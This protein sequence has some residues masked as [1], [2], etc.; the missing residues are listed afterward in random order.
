MQVGCQCACAHV[1]GVSDIGLPEPLGRERGQKYKHCCLPED[2][3]ACMPLIWCDRL[4]NAMIA[5]LVA[6]CIS[7][8]LLVLAGDSHQVLGSKGRTFAR[9]LGQ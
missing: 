6:H 5:S 2:V 9:E 1:G 3:A 8:L 4:R 7:G